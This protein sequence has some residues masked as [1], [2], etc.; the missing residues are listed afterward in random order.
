MHVLAVILNC[1][2]ILLVN[3]LNKLIKSALA[4]I[5]SQKNIFFS[6]PEPVNWAVLYSLNKLIEPYL[7]SFGKQLCV[8]LIVLT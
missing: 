7:F 2:T 5:V 6:N 4:T 3:D 1:S 8:A